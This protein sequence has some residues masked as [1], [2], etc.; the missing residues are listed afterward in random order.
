[1]ELIA[2]VQ[3][4]EADNVRVIQCDN[5]N[6]EEKIFQVKS[7]SSEWY[8]ELYLG[9]KYAFP[10]CTCK[11]WKKFLMPCKHG[12]AVFEHVPG[13]SWNSLGE[14]YTKSPFFSIDYEVFGLTKVT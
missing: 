12:V 8:H 7:M 2:K 14:I 9:D 1:M 4:I 5:E 3:N 11:D 10:T 6:S 13:V